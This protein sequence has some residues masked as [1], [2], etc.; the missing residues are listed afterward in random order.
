MADA[1]VTAAACGQAVLVGRKHRTGMQP[2]Q[3]LHGALQR[4][5]VDVVGMIVN[6]H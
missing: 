3:Q 4:L 1:R 6:R 2:L 5:Q